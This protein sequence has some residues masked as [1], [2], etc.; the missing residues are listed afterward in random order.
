[1]EDCGELGIDAFS[2]D[3]VK[4]D[5]STTL[6]DAQRLGLS[7]SQCRFVDE[8]VKRDATLHSQYFWIVECCSSSS[9]DR[10]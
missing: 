1:L 2:V 4:F 6:G 9:S 10:I 5:G 3:S 7:R 8:N